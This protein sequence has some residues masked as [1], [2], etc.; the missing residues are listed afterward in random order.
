MTSFAEE[1]RASFSARM[2]KAEFFAWLKTKKVGR[3]E[4]KDGE[5]IVHPGVSRR[6]HRVV[7]EFF[8]ALRSRLPIKSW[9]I[10]IGNFAVEIGDDIRYPD[11]LV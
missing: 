7:G 8:F 11:V 4:L 6:H 5:I 1:P 2:G 3:Y 9:D 10:A